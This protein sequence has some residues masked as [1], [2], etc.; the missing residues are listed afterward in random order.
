MSNFT[1]L[2]QSIF[3]KIDSSITANN[4]CYFDSD[5]DIAFYYDGNNKVYNLVDI[6]RTA[7][8]ISISGNDALTLNGYYK[9]SLI[10]FALRLSGSNIFL[11]TT[12]SSYSATTL[13][14]PDV[15]TFNLYFGK[16]LEYSTITGSYANIKFFQEYKDSVTSYFNNPHARYEERQMVFDYKLYDSPSASNA[17]NSFISTG[18][19]SSISATLIGTN[20]Y[21]LFPINFKRD[22]NTHGSVIPA[23]D[24]ILIEQDSKKRG[25]TNFGYGLFSNEAINNDILDYYG[26]SSAT[27]ISSFFADPLYYYDDFGNPFIWQKL[28]EHRNTVINTTRYPTGINYN[29]FIKITNAYRYVLSNFFQTAEQFVRFKSHVIQKGVNIENTLLDRNKTNIKSN[30]KTANQFS[31]NFKHPQPITKGSKQKLIELKNLHTEKVK[32]INQFVSQTN[33]Y[34]KFNAIKSNFY[35]ASMNGFH[36]I[37][38]KYF[39]PFKQTYSGQILNYLSTEGVLNTGRF[40]NFATT[41][42]IQSNSLNPIVKTGNANIKT[43]LSLNKD[44][45]ETSGNLPIPLKG[46]LEVIYFNNPAFLGNGK[47][48]SILFDSTS[49]ITGV[50]LQASYSANPSSSFSANQY[51]ISIYNNTIPVTGVLLST[52]VTS[53]TASSTAAVI[54][55]FLKYN[56]RELGNDLEQN[57]YRKYAKLS[58]QLQLDGKFYKNRE[59]SFEITSPLDRAT[60][61]PLYNF[62]CYNNNQYYFSNIFKIPCYSIN[63]TQ[64]LISVNPVFSDVVLG[65]QTFTIKNLLNDSVSSIQLNVIENAS[66]YI[67]SGFTVLRDTVDTGGG[68][69]TNTNSGGINFITETRTLT[70]DDIINGYIIFANSGDALSNPAI[71]VGKGLFVYLNSGIQT[72]GVFYNYTYDGNN[73]ITFVTPGTLI[74]GDIITITYSF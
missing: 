72:S 3:T 47:T 43:I 25:S 11:N 18:S 39:Q 33:A 61:L 12:L 54:G 15:N 60:N 29:K 1:L 5:E 22:F 42:L 53:G 36:S 51:F 71:S 40:S 7:T 8:L 70:N 55:T 58:M 37:Y 30:S 34:N 16:H 17:L 2:F 69:N 63:G 32:K 27:N 62:Y 20:K 44:V 57:Y 35:S 9:N 41:D 24:M 13:L 46:N 21:D 19:S 64:I 31:I 52:G 38:G 14:N 45:I 28:Q 48:M 73:K 6:A 66:N 67:D 59:E 65:R 10:P 23:G 74:A 50:S 56:F 4:I 49:K 26:S 68:S